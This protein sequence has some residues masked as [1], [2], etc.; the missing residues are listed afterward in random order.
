MFK[1]LKILL[2]LLFCVCFQYSNA[3]VDFPILTEIVTDNAALFSESE[4]LELREK[5]RAYE[6]ET[7]HQIVVLTVNSLE[8]NTVE[9]FALQVFENNKLGQKEADNGLLILIA[10]NDRKFRIEVGY[11]LEPIITDAF[12]SRIIR[13]TMTPEFKKGDFYKGVDLATSEIIKLIDDPKYREE[14]AN[15]KEEGSEMPIWGK[16]I[17]AFI[18]FLFL[19]LCIV[20]G[21]VFLYKS[22][23]QLISVFRG[24]ITG[25][26]SIVL[27]PFLF[28]SSLIKVTFSLIFIFLPFP[29]GGLLVFIE[30]GG[31]VNV[32][33]FEVLQSWSLIVTPITI[34]LLVVLF[35]VLPLIIAI[36]TRSNQNFISVMFSFLKIDK[37][38]MS[39]NFSSSGSSSSYRRS[40]SSYSR[41]GSSYRSSSSSSSFF[42]GGGRSGGGGA[43][44]SW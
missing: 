22:F 8:N 44:G 34:I 14:F 39:K 5:L 27:F 3:Q 36:F 20:A 21:G 31:N 43:S 24:L 10:K 32:Y 18:Y 28:I 1:K 29:V 12:S 19:L 37:S 11:G 35:T 38:F 13:E 7:T 6:I 40:G 17:I 33:Y 16:V 15:L 26:I 25:K 23:K 4:T 2:V 9:N 41:S 42:G 30:E